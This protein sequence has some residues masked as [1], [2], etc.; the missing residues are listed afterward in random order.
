LAFSSPSYSYSYSAPPLTCI[1]K[2]AIF[3]SIATRLTSSPF[4]LRNGLRVH[5]FI[6][7]QD[8][9]SWSN[10]L[11]PFEYEFECRP[12]G[13]EYEYDCTAADWSVCIP[14]E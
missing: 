1:E 8:I 7:P 6:S 11:A 5:R 4:A 14:L 13:T 9:F 12:C 2:D 3:V 10:I